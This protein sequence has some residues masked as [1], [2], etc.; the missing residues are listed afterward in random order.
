MLDRRC[1]SAPPEWDLFRTGFRWLPVSAVCMSNQSHQASLFR[2]K[3]TRR[4]ST[5][6]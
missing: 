3:Q 5:E 4:V 6:M 2:D 1:L